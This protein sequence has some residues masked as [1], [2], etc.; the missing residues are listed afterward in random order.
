MIGFVFRGGGEEGGR[1]GG[2]EGRTTAETYLVS[3]ETTDGSRPHT[4]P[5]IK[6]GKLRLRGSR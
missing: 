3:I 5:N 4:S 2:R 6:R 1:E